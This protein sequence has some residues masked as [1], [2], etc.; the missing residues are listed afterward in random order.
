MLKVNMIIDVF[1]EKERATDHQND[2]D[3][4]D[5][6]SIMGNLVHDLS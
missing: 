1:N 6:T 4:S 3:N 5:D 2:A